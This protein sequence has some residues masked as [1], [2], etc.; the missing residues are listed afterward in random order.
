MSKVNTLAELFEA[1]LRDMYDS[2]KQI[3]K[4]LPK[5][6]KAADDEQLSEALSSH[7]QETKEQITRL[8]QAFESLEL[9]P[10][11][12]PCSGMKGILE[13]GSEML[14]EVQTEA[15]LDAAIISGCQRVEHYEITGYGTLIAWAKLLG[16]EEAERLLTENLEEEKAADEKLNE[17]AESSINERANAGEDEEEEQA[18]E[19]EE[20]VVSSSKR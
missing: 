12:K 17:L 11:G 1:E 19:E 3:T 4:A 6:I 2:E 9:K 20:E 15:V 13:E 10:R 14:E 16:Y 5:M 7:L 8:E 18:D